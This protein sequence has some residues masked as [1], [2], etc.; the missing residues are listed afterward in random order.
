VFRVFEKSSE[1]IK[2]CVSGFWKIFR[3]NKTL[4]FGFLKKLQNQRLCWALETI[5]RTSWIHKTS[6]SGHVCWNFR[7]PIQG[8]NTFYDSR[9]LGHVLFSDCNSYKHFRGDDAFMYILSIGALEHDLFLCPL[10]TT[11]GFALLAWTVQV[12]LSLLLLFPFCWVFCL[13][14]FLTGFHHVSIPW[15]DHGINYS[16]DT[17]WIAK[18]LVFTLNLSNSTISTLLS[19]ICFLHDPFLSC[20]YCISSIVLSTTNLFYNTLIC[21]LFIVFPH[22]G[23]CGWFTQCLFPHRCTH[24]YH[25]L[26]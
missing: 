20:E 9:T 12:S 26:Y 15:T 11:L 17:R 7:I 5:Q 6:T 4:C 3:N 18:S 10:M 21:T 23:Y 16:M 1:I 22:I 25:Q 2:P 24:L 14:K 8:Q 19:S 13:M